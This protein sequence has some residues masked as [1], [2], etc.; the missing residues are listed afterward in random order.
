VSNLPFGCA[1]IDTDFGG[2]AWWPL[3]PSGATSR[4]ATNFTLYALKV[5]GRR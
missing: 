2:P 5:D 4:T 3:P 1:Q